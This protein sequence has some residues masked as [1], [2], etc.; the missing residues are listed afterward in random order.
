MPSE[1][2]NQEDIEEKKTRITVKLDDF[3]H[4]VINK[5]A[6]NRNI[7]LSNSMRNIVHQWIESNPDLLKKNYGVDIKEI[8]DEIFSESASLA[9]D[10]TL[11]KIE[12]DIIKELPEFFEIVEVVDI[13][14]LADHFDVP[15]K[16]IKKIIFTHS[17]EIK[18]VGLNLKLKEGQIFKI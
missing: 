5:M 9:L 8:S 16:I 11:R 18:K 4:R 1:S 2:T 15:N 12:K 3:D 13:D 17:K 7:S 6:T 10:K 14:D